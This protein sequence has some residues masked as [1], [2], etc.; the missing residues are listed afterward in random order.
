MFQK[1]SEALTEDEQYLQSLTKERMNKVITSK[2]D[3]SVEVNS[4]QLLALPIPLQRRGVQL[5]LNYLY[6]NVPSSFSARHIQQFLEWA[7]NGKRLG[8]A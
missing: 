7:E 3:T 4:S 5:I 8:S 6:E 1:V 2:S